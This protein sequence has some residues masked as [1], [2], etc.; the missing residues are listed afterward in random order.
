M[1]QRIEIGAEGEAA[2]QLRAMRE[3]LKVCRPF[4][5]AEGYDAIVDNGRRCWKVQVKSTETRQRK[6]S[7]SVSCGRG[8]RK[9]AY[10]ESEVDFLAI[11][12][13]PEETW[14]IVP[15]EVV[16][17]RVRMTVP[18]KTCED[19]GP[20]GRWIGRWDLLVWGKWR[21]RPD[22]K[23]TKADLPERTWGRGRQASSRART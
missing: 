18:S 11:H 1:R 2:F 12:V 4:E 19:L 20:M 5:P 3:G 7:Y 10:R 22:R 13:I 14:F 21:D 16:A 8:K 15:I 9:E 6:K 23:P 17:G